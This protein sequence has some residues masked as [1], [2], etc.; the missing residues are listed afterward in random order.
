[1][2]L[3]LSAS[4]LLSALSEEQLISDGNGE[5]SLVSFILYPP[6]YARSAST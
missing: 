2:I 6:F 3:M 1:M 5:L 4:M